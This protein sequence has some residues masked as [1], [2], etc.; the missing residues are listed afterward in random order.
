V[1]KRIS[2]LIAAAIM[3]LSL[4][5]PPA[6]AAPPDCD[7]Q[8]N[9]CKEQTS[10]QTVQV[11]DPEKRNPKFFETVEITTTEKQR[12]NFN[13]GTDD[14]TNESETSEEQI[15]CQNPSGKPNGP[16]CR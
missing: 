7:E 1:I 12:G 5:A 15:D 3:A 10:T 6:F 14:A 11:D 16:T 9:G 8:P 4:A 13:S 2:L